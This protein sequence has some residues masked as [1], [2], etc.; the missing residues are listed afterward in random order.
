MV[1]WLCRRLPLRGEVSWCLHHTFENTHTNMAK[2]LQLLHLEFRSCFSPFSCYNKIPVASGLQ[3]TEMYS[4]QFWRMGSPR[5]TY[6]HG[7]LM[8]ALFLVHSHHLLT[9]SLH[10]ERDWNLS[11]ASFIRHQSHLWK[12]HSH[13]LSTSQRPHLL[14][15]SL[16]T[17]AWMFVSII[18]LF[19]LCIGDFYNKR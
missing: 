4:S 11:G 12:F 3:T 2:Y 18:L 9:V 13:Y 15:S 5:S 8:R 16:R 14:I 1:L 17:I 7:H 19:F 6:Q 10:G